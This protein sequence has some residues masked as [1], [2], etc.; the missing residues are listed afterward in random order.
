MFPVLLHKLGALPDS[1]LG[2]KDVY[3]KE[4]DQTKS[5]FERLGRNIR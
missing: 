5:P 4:I 1:L 2:L 3:Y